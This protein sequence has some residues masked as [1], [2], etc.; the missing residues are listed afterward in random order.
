MDLVACQRPKVG[1][2]VVAAIENQHLELRR[3][4]RTRVSLA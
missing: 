2:T 3:H 4:W 1:H